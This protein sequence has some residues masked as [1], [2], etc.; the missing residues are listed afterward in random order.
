[1]KILVTG[2]NGFV[3]KNLVET[4]KSIKEHKDRTRNILVEDIFLFDVNNSLK[5][6]EAYTKE[7]DYIV[8]L[9]GINRPKNPEE[10]YEGNKGFIETLCSYLKKHHN[11]CP[12]IVSS[13]IQVG[14]DNDYAKSKKEGEDFLKSF[15]K[16]NGNE[17]F[18][19]NGVDQIITVLQPLGVITLLMI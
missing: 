12:I 15:S 19:E 16:E 17:V 1:M 7:C 14:K 18:L 6:L 9:A 4:L 3:G 11:Q 13:S 5:E 8:N 2:A 10:F